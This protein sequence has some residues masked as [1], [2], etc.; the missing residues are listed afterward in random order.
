MQHDPFTVSRYPGLDAFVPT[1]QAQRRLRVCI[2]TEEIVG[3]IANGGIASTYFDLARLLVESGH[4][5][6]VLYLKGEVCHNKTIGHWVAFYADLGVT[7]VPLPASEDEYESVAP[8]WQERLYNAWKWLRDQP[9]FDVVHTSEWRGGAYYALLAK[10][11]GLA[12]QDTL[13]IVKTSSPHIWNRHYQMRFLDNEQMLGVMYPEQMTVELS[14]L[15]VGGSAHLLSFM[16]HMGYSLP[17]SRTFVQPNVILFDRLNVEDKR[18]HYEIGDTVETDELVFFGRLEQRKGLEIFCDAVDFAVAR[19]CKPSR[20]SFLGKEGTRIPSYP[21]YKTKAFIE[22]RAESWPCEVVIHDDFNQHAAISYMLKQPCIAVMPS[23]IENSTM[24]VYEALVYR[25]PFIATRVGGT[26]ELIN[27]Q[28]HEHVLCDANPRDLARYIQRV[29]SDGQVVAAPAFSN[30]ENLEVWRNF[31]EFLAESIESGSVEQTLSR[32][33]NGGTATRRQAGLQRHAAAPLSVCVAHTGDVGSLRELIVSLDTREVEICI[34]VSGYNDIQG[35]DPE[36]YLSELADRGV[37][38]V[39]ASECTLGET[40][41]QLA[42]CASGDAFVFLRS[43]IHLPGKEFAATIST[44]LSHSGASALAPMYEKVSADGA[45]S[46]YLTMGGDLALGFMHRHALCGEVLAVRAEAFHAVGRFSEIHGMGGLSQHL[47]VRLVDQGYVLEALPVVLYEEHA[48]RC[49]WHLDEQTAQYFTSM[50]LFEKF[51]LHLRK[52]YLATRY[53]AKGSAKGGAKVSG[54]GQQGDIS[55][56]RNI[57]LSGVTW[58]N[59]SLFEIDGGSIAKRV[60]IGLDPERH[61]FGVFVICAEAGNSSPRLVV[62][63]RRN[64]LTELQMKPCR[65]GFHV[66]WPLEVAEFRMGKASRMVSPLSVRIVHDS[67]DMGEFKRYLKLEYGEDGVLG[68]SSQGGIE[69]WPK[70][71]PPSPPFNMRHWLGGCSST[72]AG[73]LRRLVR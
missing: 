68:V 63:N 52:I 70:G 43:D 13:F 6:T 72:V 39:E 33:A 55:G 17:A 32:I 20:I 12:F 5:V 34:G 31:H 67:R 51:P 25:I 38:V 65:N 14:D 46:Q 24:A 30:E 15:T 35:S 26:P 59:G 18:P 64:V 4:D 47:A 57:E 56:A 62:E 50:P 29:L 40:Y 48:G 7:F 11:Q 23:L 44:A 37:K 1:I 21:E 16:E 66:T 2:A 60:R 22:L 42:A 71:I 73:V 41:N 69:Y 53:S 54:S 8:L 45:R 3:P 9:T 49:R 27:G 61:L 10:R 28:D 58:Q 19:G 36:T